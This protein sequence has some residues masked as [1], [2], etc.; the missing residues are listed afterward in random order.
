MND[1]I[2]S[3]SFLTCWF[4]V[5]PPNLLEKAAGSCSAFHCLCA[6]YDITE[7]FHISCFIS[8]QVNEVV[9][10]IEIISVL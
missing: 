2:F 5:I 9:P 6:T 4:Y 8:R 3:L 7:L 1:L 10:Q